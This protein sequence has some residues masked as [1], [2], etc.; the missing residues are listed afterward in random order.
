MSTP[1]KPPGSIDRTV[2]VSCET[3]ERAVAERDPAEDGGRP[4]L[5]PHAPKDARAQ[6]SIEP[7]PIKPDI[8]EPDIVMSAGAEPV[9]SFGAPE[10]RRLPRAGSL[11]PVPGLPPVDSGERFTDSLRSP[12][13]L[14][15]ERVV[16]PPMTSPRRSLRGPLRILAAGV[17]AAP[18][19]YY[20]SIGG[21]PAGG[22]DPPPGSDAGLQMEAYVQRI[23]GPP[24]MSVGQ[25]GLWP[26]M[27]QD[28]DPETLAPGELSSEQSE[29]SQTA[30]ISGSATMAMSEPAA[31]GAESPPSS[32]AVRTLDPEELEFLTRRGEQFALAGDLVTARALFQRAA[33]AGNAT[34]AM[35]LGATYDPDVL[36]KL[37]VVGV[38]ADVEKA[39]SWYQK[40]ESQ[41]SA[42]ATRRLQALANR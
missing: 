27:A 15:P 39:R 4:P 37:G 40:A 42:Q 35:A 25:P 16:P 18:I 12:F 11:P 31:T 24:W 17:V 23:V 2:D 5:S 6:P 28:D 10:G 26:T 22:L 41:G 20:C 33:D 38:G 13:S 1:R 19:A 36:A 14:V 34:A 21:L 3:L 9:P 8:I 7:H 29:T 30:T 32:K